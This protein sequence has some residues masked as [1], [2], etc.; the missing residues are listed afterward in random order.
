MILRVCVLL[1]GRG[2]GWAAGS[3]EVAFDYVV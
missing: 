1:G 3:H 2:G